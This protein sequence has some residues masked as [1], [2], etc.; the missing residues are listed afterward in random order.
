MPI[1]CNANRL[2]ESSERI[3]SIS[4]AQGLFLCVHLEGRDRNAERPLS[5]VGVIRETITRASNTCLDLLVG[6]VGAPKRSTFD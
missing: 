2:V 6:K 5:Q 3:N 1:H 4:M